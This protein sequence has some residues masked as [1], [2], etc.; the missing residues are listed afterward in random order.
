MDPVGPVMLVPAGPTD[1]VGPVLPTP[2]PVGP[3]APSPPATSWIV[4]V[5]AGEMNVLP[6]LL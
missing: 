6:L 3:V 4:I 1:P 2:G 5:A